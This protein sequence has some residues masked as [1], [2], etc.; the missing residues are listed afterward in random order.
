M[1]P[2][3]ALRRRAA[4]A[5]A[6]AIAIVVPLAATSP[7]QAS[8]GTGQTTTISGFVKNADGTPASGVSVSYNNYFCNLSDD[9]DGSADDSDSVVTSTSGAFSF[10]AYATQ[11][12]TISL[13]GPSLYKGQLDLMP[14]LAAGTS[15]AVFTLATLTDLNLTVPG[16]PTGTGVQAY[17]PVNVYG[18]KRW[19]PV[20][21]GT[22]DAA[23]K[24]TLTVVAGYRYAVRL[25][26]SGD[27]YSQYLGAGVSAPSLN[28]GAGSFVAP[29]TGTSFD[30]SLTAKKS[31]PV[32]VNLA[33]VD[34]GATVSSISWASLDLYGSASDTSTSATSITLRGLVPGRN[35]LRLSG[36]HGADDVFGEKHDVVVKDG[37]STPVTTSI[38]ASVA[39]TA[40]SS[41]TAD[42]VVSTSGTFQVGKKLTASTTFTG[43]AAPFAG[44][45]GTAIRYFWFGGTFSG[46][47]ADLRLVGEGTSYTI[48]ANQSDDDL[49]LVYA[50]VSAPGQETGTGAGIAWVAPTLL[51]LIG[52]STPAYPSGAIVPGDSPFPSVLPT[53]SGKAAI[54]QTLTASPGTWSP[55]PTAFRYQ[56]TRSGKAIAGATART[57]KATAADAGK[58]LSVTVTP[59]KAGYTIRS[60][61]SAPTAA[62]AK[63][64]ATISAKVAKKSVKHGKKAKVTVKV[65]AAGVTPSGKVTVTFGKKKVTKSL[66][67]G[68]VTIT[69]PKLKKGKVTVK[70]TYKGSATVSKASLAAKKAKKL[71]LKVR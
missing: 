39:G 25:Q 23:G 27:Y 68:K 19:Y 12:Y 60:V 66:K 9:I 41:S 29:A 7:A 8:P 43:S 45:P 32:N 34:V 40:L 31:S 2:T 64:T 63:A 37:T 4:V 38:T 6:A 67:K 20:G 14:I 30:Q 5:V 62:V 71:T 24:V 22:T 10:P 3:S 49:L 1:A 69:S 53:V 16:A 50:F 35:Y 70:V 21:S 55:Q 26:R 11:C 47:G 51:P 44:A 54:G 52:S 36:S 33:N 15:G 56:W 18:G 61:T 28:G 65:T 42:L 13:G 59:V 57:Y 48:P 17:V 46:S 58:K